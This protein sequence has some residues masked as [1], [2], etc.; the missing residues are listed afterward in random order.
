M[1]SDR[2]VEFRWTA[3]QKR[4]ALLVKFSRMVI[5]V[6]SSAEMAKERRLEGQLC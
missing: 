1:W 6:A 4:Q 3:Y 2:P 5:R